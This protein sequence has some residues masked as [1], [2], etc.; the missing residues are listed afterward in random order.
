MN[1]VA[2]IGRNINAKGR[3]QNRKV[4]GRSK[5]TPKGAAGKKTAPQEKKVAPASKWYAAEDIKVPLPNRKKNRITKL[6]ASITPGTILILLAGA[7]RG[8]RVVFLKQL[9]S[10]LLLVTGPRKINGVALRRVNQAFVI[11]T[12]TKIDVSAVDSSSVDDA[13]FRSYEAAAKGAAKGEFLADDK[14]EKVVSDEKKTKQAQVDAGVLA[15]V[16]AVPQLKEYLNASFRLK[17]SDRPHLLK[18]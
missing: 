5:Y 6:R 16:K 17:K 3:T 13:F 9:P 15:A 8:K 18:F 2:T 14:K 11:A 7:A 10:G 12:S 1:R 4:S